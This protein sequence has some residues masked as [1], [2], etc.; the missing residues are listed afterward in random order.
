MNHVGE[1]NVI[2]D[3]EYREVIADE[4]PIPVDGGLE[5]DGEA[6]RV[7]Q[8]LRR[9]LAVDHSGEADDDGRF[10]PRGGEDGGGGETGEVEGGDEVTSGGY[11]TG[12]NDAL[13][14]AFGVEPAQ[15][16]KGVDVLQ[17]EWTVAGD[18][19]TMLIG[20]DMM[21]RLAGEMMSGGGRRSSDGTDDDGNK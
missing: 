8:G 10:F 1:F 5:L 7:A 9:V 17:K 2:A 4:I 14:N 15:L 19:L 21:P 13:G 18:G 3:E 16:L 20:P 6:T 12:V 11:A